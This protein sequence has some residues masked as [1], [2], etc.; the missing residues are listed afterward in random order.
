MG[1]L[2]PKIDRRTA[3][4]IAAGGAATSGTIYRRN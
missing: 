4:D 3:E 2:A 1:K